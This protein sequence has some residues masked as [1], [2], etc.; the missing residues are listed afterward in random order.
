MNRPE[1]S[2]KHPWSVRPAIVNWIVYALYAACAVSVLLDL[3]IHRH[4][5]IGFAG[6]FA[7]YAWYGFVA[8]VG[9]VLAARGMRRILMRDENYY[10]EADE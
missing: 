10:G 6:S 2:T 7:F 1:D 9:L 4:E 8:C 5:K 3:L